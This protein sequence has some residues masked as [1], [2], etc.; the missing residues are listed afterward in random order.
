[1]K[2][3]IEPRLTI[4]PPP[5]LRI[6]GT[7]CFETSATPTTLTSRIRFHSSTVASIPRR[8]KTAALL[9]RILIWLNAFTAWPTI[10]TMLASSATSVSTNSARPPRE[11]IPSATA[12]PFSTL[13]SAM[14]TAAPARPKTSQVALP[15][16]SAPPVT[17]ATFPFKRGMKDTRRE[18][19]ISDFGFRICRYPRPGRVAPTKIG[20][21]LRRGIGARGRRDIDGAGD[22]P[23]AA[24]VLFVELV[25]LGMLL[26][27]F[28]RVPGVVD[29]RFAGV[30][31]RTGRRRDADD[32]VR[33]VLM[34]NRHSTP[35][36]DGIDAHIAV[37]V[38]DP[39]G[40]P[41]VAC[42]DHISGLKHA[43]SRRAS[44]R[45]EPAKLD[46]PG[47]RVGDFGRIED[48]GGAPRRRAVPAAGKLLER[49][50]SGAARLLV[51]PLVQLLE[52]RQ[53]AHDDFEAVGFSRRCDF[54]DHRV[55]GGKQ[56]FR[57]LLAG[58][59]VSGT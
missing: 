57:G 42:R 43:D 29:C 49:G 7:T 25:S 8:T 13:T 3:E 56:F 5:A 21:E 41:A 38:R 58:G 51:G 10:R 17:M 52:D 11:M 39:N 22:A 34:S 37:A 15:I 4:A 16:P 33:F 59:K 32:D 48:F 14:T 54:V 1:M 50:R 40:R 30:F 18:F 45:I 47:R 36:F 19:R 31:P 23:V 44:G 28:R 20:G 27:E 9:T 6:S 55:A 46:L 53:T 12:R 24:A 2:L 35:P 26:F